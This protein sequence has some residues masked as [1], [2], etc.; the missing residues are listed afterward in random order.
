MTSE[1]HAMAADRSTTR[2]TAPHIATL[3]SNLGAPWRVVDASLTYDAEPSSMRESATLVTQA[4][5]I[6]EQLNHHPDITVGYHRLRIT[7]TTHDS[8]G[9]TGL[10]FAFAAQLELWRRAR[11][12]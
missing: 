11:A 9:L 4:A 7:I 1:L 3:V 6:A 10:D 12:Q 2:L 8:G 5:D